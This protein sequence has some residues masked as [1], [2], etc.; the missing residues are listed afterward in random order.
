M[1]IAQLT[2]L[3]I[4]DGPQGEL[5]AWGAARA[6]ERVNALR[7]A[8]AAVVI[9]G[10]VTMTA[11]PE[12][13]RLAAAILAELTAPVYVIPGNHDDRAG[14]APPLARTAAG[15]TASRWSTWERWPW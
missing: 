5:A 14:C 13:Y 3:H 7:P 1:L 9:T 12:S 10:D 8:P 6:V 15:S 2:D 11:P 4:A